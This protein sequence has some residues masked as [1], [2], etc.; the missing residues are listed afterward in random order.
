MRFHNE[1]IIR[2]WVLT[3][4]KY[5]V[6]CS[7][8]SRKITVDIFIFIF[9]GEKFSQMLQ[10]TISTKENCTWTLSQKFKK[11]VNYWHNHHHEKQWN[12]HHRGTSN[13]EGK[14]QEK[15]PLR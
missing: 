3:E 5:S 15:V 2:R 11:Q 1:K 7:C 4:N 6:T 13:M 12:H 9:T 14:A 10:E 8:L